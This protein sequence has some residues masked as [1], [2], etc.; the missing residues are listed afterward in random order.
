MVSHSFLLFFFPRPI[1]AGPVLAQQTFCFSAKGILEH[2][3]HNQCA[4]HCS[5][6]LQP[7]IYGPKLFS[8][9]NKRNT[10][11]QHKQQNPLAPERGDPGTD[12]AQR[13]KSEQ[14]LPAAVSAFWMARAFC[15][16]P[17]ARFFQAL[18]SSCRH[19]ILGTKKGHF[20]FA[21]EMS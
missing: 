20:F 19:L 3:S 1:Q 16:V 14:L 11:K 12:A 15:P 6:R 17:S 4:K 7:G 13:A 9:A 2:D 18:C 10:N 8:P 21:E 5:Y